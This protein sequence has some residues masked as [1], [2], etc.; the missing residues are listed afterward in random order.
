METLRPFFSYYGSKWRLTAEFPKPQYPVIINPFCGSASYALR[1]HQ[2]GVILNDA[3]P[4]ITA[5]WNLLTSKDAEEVIRAIPTDISH[6]S[7]L[8]PEFPDGARWLVGFWIARASGHP[9]QTASKQDWTRWGTK[10][11]SRILKQLPYIF[12]WKVC[13]T[14][15]YEDLPDI[16]CTTIVDPPYV[17]KGGFYEKSNKDIDFEKL[18]EWCLSRKGQVIVCE[19]EG[20]NW[21]P[22][23]FLKEVRTTRNLTASREVLY[24]RD[25][26]GKGLK[27]EGI[28]RPK[29]STDPNSI[30]SLKPWVKEGVSRA[31][32]YRQ[33]A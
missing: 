15:S 10:A 23:R 31:T 5:I 9:R 24:Y 16:E 29:G 19:Q 27:R 22:F 2:K 3:N 32:W 20:A 11:K 21:L 8:G 13:E 6:T 12:H 7:E 28:G 33:Q 17:Q 4:K 30:S 14:G 26:N 25:K 18:A 1:H